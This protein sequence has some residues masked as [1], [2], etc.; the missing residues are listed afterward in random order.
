[1]NIINEAPNYA[2]K[3]PAIYSSLLNNKQNNQIKPIQEEE[4]EEQNSNND[5]M[6]ITS[7]DDGYIS[8]SGQFKLWK[9]SKKV[10]ENLIIAPYVS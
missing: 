4:E 3:F 8:H 5:D 7:N 9:E 1:M 10:S 2:I 6:D